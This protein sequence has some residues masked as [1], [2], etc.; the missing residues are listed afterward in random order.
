MRGPSQLGRTK[1]WL[2]WIL[3]LAFAAYSKTSRYLQP[4]LLVQRCQPSGIFPIPA[5]PF[6]WDAM[7]SLPT[8]GPGEVSRH[9]WFGY[10]ADKSPQF[11]IFNIIL[12]L[13]TIGLYNGYVK[14]MC[15]EVFH[16]R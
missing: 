4:V 14:N 16:E 7:P 3:S 6:S 10:Q 12:D 11:L 9:C 15:S 1:I 8:G 13:T 2:S 5:I